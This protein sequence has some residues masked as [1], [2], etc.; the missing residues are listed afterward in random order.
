MSKVILNDE[1]YRMGV[2]VVITLK[3][4]VRIYLEEWK[5]T[6]FGQIIFQ[7]W[8]LFVAQH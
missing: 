5:K 3:Y 4:F 6:W 2:E 8:N 1:L 7:Y